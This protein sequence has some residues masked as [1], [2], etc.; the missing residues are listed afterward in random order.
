MASTCMFHAKP[1]EAPPLTV[2]GESSF[3][4]GLETQEG[5]RTPYGLEASMTSATATHFLAFSSTTPRYSGSEVFDISRTS[6]QPGPWPNCSG[7]P[8]RIWAISSD[9]RF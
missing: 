4:S 5:K 7:D 6:V 2:L 9:R 8:E 1:M 3:Q